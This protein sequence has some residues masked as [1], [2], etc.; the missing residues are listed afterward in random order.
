M[1]IYMYMGIFSDDSEPDISLFKNKK[2][3]I[4]YINVEIDKY[5][6]QYDIDK[7]KGIVGMDSRHFETSDHEMT[8]IFREMEVK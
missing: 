5:C 7:Q 1:K 6:E 3:C 4:D 8:F 2:D